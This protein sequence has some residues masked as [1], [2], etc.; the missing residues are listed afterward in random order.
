MNDRKTEFAFSKIFS[1]SLVIGVLGGQSGS[2][3]SLVVQITV[4]EEEEGG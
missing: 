3:M 2:N 4:E 1:E